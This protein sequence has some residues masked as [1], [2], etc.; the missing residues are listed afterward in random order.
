MQCEKMEKMRILALDGGGIRGLYSLRILQLLADDL[1]PKLDL[2]RDFDCLSGTSVGSLIVLSLLH[3]LPPSELITVYSTLGRYI[4]QGSNFFSGRKKSQAK[5][6]SRHLE[7]VLK[8]VLKADLQ[9][10]D[11]HDKFICIPAVELKN[12]TTGK[13]KSK[14]YHNFAASPYANTP[15]IDIALRSCAAP[16]YFPAHENCVD[17]GVFATNP[18]LA[19]FSTAIDPEMG[20][21]SVDE[22]SILNIGTGDNPSFI[23]EN[24]DWS[25][26]RWVQKHPTAGD[27]PLI[28]MTVDLLADFQ[29]YPLQLLLKERFCRINSPLIEQIEMDDYK[30]A[31]ELIESADQ[32]RKNHPK[33]WQQK[34]QW[35]EEHICQ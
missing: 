33:E 21:R 3:K 12:E 25:R 30:K 34:L 16:G 20:A 18:A 11:I 22:I 13:W 19:A 17:G 14:I 1:F 28:S 15:L 8:K 9:V 35:I 5:Y 10:K 31:A 7:A 24:I 32:Y 29:A 6:G 2:Y 27:A 23:D 4:F 26:T